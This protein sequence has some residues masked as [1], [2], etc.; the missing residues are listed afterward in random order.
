MGQCTSKRFEGNMEC[1]TKKIY[2]EL[3]LM[4][5]K[6]SAIVTILQNEKEKKHKKETA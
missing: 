3:S 1:E 6:L 2:S 5:T 4:N